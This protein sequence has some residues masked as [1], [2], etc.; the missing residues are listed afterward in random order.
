MSPLTHDAVGF[1]FAHFVGDESFEVEQVHFAL[2]DGPDPLHWRGINGGRPVLTS[3]VGTLG[4][5]DPFLVRHPDGRVFC[6]ATDLLINVVGDWE[7]AVRHGS[8]S[9]VVWETD[10]L[11]HWS[12]PRLLEVAPPNAGDAWA[13]KAYYDPVRDAFRILFSATLYSTE[14]RAGGSYHR[15]V[16]VWTKDFS[17]VSPAQV[18]LDHGDGVHHGTHIIDLAVLRAGDAVH[19]IY[20]NRYFVQEQGPTM[21]GLFTTVRTGIGEGIIDHGEGPAIFAGLDGETWYLFLDENGLRGYVPLLSHDLDSGD[22]VLPDD[23]S[24]PHKCRHGSV[25]AVTA[26]E[27]ARLEELL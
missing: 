12:A 17:S 21:D 20:P 3:T 23:Y 8:R 15:I 18:Y 16:C 13:P 19:R 6:I 7:Q 27:Y 5:R 22:W 1:L 26:A 10:D 4:A 9:I 2:S 24:L 25:I 14:D 11:V